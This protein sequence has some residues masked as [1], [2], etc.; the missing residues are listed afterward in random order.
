MKKHSGSAR[1]ISYVAFLG[2]ALMASQG[3]AAEPFKNGADDPVA[4]DALDDSS[5]FIK[6]QDLHHSSQADI[7][8]D[9]NTFVIDLQNTTALTADVKKFFSD[10][11]TAANQIE[12]LHH[13][14]R[15]LRVDNNPQTGPLIKP[16]RG[17]SDLN[18]AVTA[19]FKD[20]DTRVAAEAAVE[21]DLAGLRIAILAQDKA[22]VTSNS[23]QFFKDR[24]TAAQARLNEAADV[25]TIK[26]DVKF[27]GQKLALVKPSKS[28]DLTA[29]VSTFLSDRAKWL[30]DD[31]AITTARNTMRAALGT[32][33]LEAAVLA[34]LNARRQHH[35]DGLQLGLDR[36][37]LKVDVGLAR[38]K[39]PK[40]KDLKGGGK[41]SGVE[42][43]ADS[44]NTELDESSEDNGEK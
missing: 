24:F 21:S 23:N 37:A 18:T 4:H 1:I 34:W 32:P 30:S 42:D 29:H 43:S 25:Q 7:S 15:Q 44:P 35:V 28:D 22:G 33:S 36:S 6:D 19:Y 10:R 31:V 12:T 3:S 39:D 8:A 13:D 38:Q 11:S 5:T 41:I 27:K 2:I 9:R 40:K 20:F 26:K 14:R 17:S 16:G